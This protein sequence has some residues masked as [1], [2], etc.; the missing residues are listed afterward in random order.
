MKQKLTLLFLCFAMVLTLCTFFTFG[1]SAE[2]EV[3]VS[4]TADKWDG[5]STEAPF[6]SGASEDDPVII[7]TAAKLAYWSANPDAYVSC[8]VR[9]DANIDLNGKNFT[10]ISSFSGTFDGNNCT[11]SNLYIPSTGSTLGFF[12]TAIGTIKNLT[13]KDAQVAT[14]STA[15]TARGIFVATAKDGILNIENCHVINGKARGNTEGV[16]LFVGNGAGNCT[17]NFK[18]CTASGELFGTGNCNLGAFLGGVTKSGSKSNYENCVSSVVINGDAKTAGGFI[19]GATQG[20]CDATFTNCIFNGAINVTKNPAGGFVAYPHNGQTH[21]LTGCA[22]YGTV[23]S[24]TGNAGGLIGTIGNSLTVKIN[25]CAVYGAVSTETAKAGGIAGGYGGGYQK[26]YASNVLVLATVSCGEGGMAGAIVGS[27]NSGKEG[28]YSNIYT[29]YGEDFFVGEV[30]ATNKATYSGIALTTTLELPETFTEDLWE[31][32][33]LPVISGISLTLGDSITVNVYAK[34][35]IMLK[36]HQTEGLYVNGQFVTVGEPTT[37]RGEKYTK[38]VFDTFKV[39]DLSEAFV[40]SLL[41]SDIAQKTYAFSD[42]LANVY[43]NY[44]SD[45]DLIALIES[46]VYY[47]AA[48]EANKNGTTNLLTAFAEKT[49]YVVDDSYVTTKFAAL[50]LHKIVNSG[51]DLTLNGEN[52][53]IALSLGSSVRPYIK[54]NGAA[55][56][57]V[58]FNKTFDIECAQADDAFTA[59]FLFATSLEDAF[60]IK[61]YDENGDLIGQM[62]YTVATYILSALENERT[63]ET[64]ATLAMATAVYMNQAKLYNIAKMPQGN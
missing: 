19:G 56:V 10:P 43:N 9:L 52:T 8:Y 60:R 32:N 55:S 46:L 24:K 18:N 40:L 21:T 35:V 57:K 61:A 49:G 37:E 54:V 44:Q 23:S 38:Y 33:A 11:I 22:S 59:E 15:N 62:K 14:N 45:A 63:T 41:G 12:K 20:G 47:G 7:D 42:Y 1:A 64:E 26:S 16:G 36:A 29:T 25:D 3:P 27:L 4:D 34:H 50:E 58:D 6:G 5:T 13:F 2:G 17:V 30:A 48:A 51:A 53:E 39:T 28:S 31:V